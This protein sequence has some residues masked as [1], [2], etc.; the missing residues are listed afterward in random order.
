MND[1]YKPPKCDLDA[2]QSLGEPPKHAY[3]VFTLFILEAIV[4]IATNFIGSYDL[5]GIG[6]YGLEALIVYGATAYILY[7]AY[8]YVKKGSKQINSLIY[9]LIAIG[10]IFNGPDWLQNGVLSGL[11]EFLSF[12]GVI[13]LAP[14]L[15]LTKVKLNAWF[16]N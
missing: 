5:E 2:E 11:G 13:V 6:A 3:V 9:I 16:A 15:Y 1:I 8:S 4:I 10:V 14:A 7:L 12:A